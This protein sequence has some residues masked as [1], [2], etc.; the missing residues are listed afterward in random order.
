[1]WLEVAQRVVLVKG[2][3]AKGYS[4]TK[5]REAHPAVRLDADDPKILAKCSCMNGQSAKCAHI[6][7]LLLA[8]RQVTSGISTQLRTKRKRISTEYRKYYQTN[9]LPERESVESDG[10]LEIS[11]EETERENEFVEQ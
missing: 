7:S 3:C 8:L 9:K 4:T 11:E 6:I 2:S 1:M 10:N 5:K